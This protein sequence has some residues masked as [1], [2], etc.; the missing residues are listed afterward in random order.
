MKYFV[1]WFV[2]LLF[3]SPIAKSNPYTIEWWLFPGYQN[4]PNAQP[5]PEPIL[6]A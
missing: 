6:L 1:I 4:L 2:L 3:P 5:W